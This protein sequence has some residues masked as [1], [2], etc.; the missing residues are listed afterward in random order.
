AMDKQWWITCD[1][2]Y[3]KTN[4]LFF[5]DSKYMT[6]K[7]ANGKN[8]YWSRGNGWVVAG[9]CNVLAYMPA[10]YPTRPRYE[11]LLKEMTEK[12][13][14][15]Q[16]P[17]GLWTMSLADPEAN[18]NAETSGTSFFCY[19]MTWGVN[20]KLLDRAKFEPVIDKAWTAMNAHILPNGLIGAVQPVGEA[21]ITTNYDKTSQPYAV[22]AYLLAGCEIIKMH[23]DK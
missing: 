11:Q 19:A 20:N 10:D 18:P 9:T 14:S 17:S 2:L 3:D 16:Q 5:R 12:L 1:K 4:H 21:P 15:I 22:G 6:Q 23:G 7:T 8:V 13:A